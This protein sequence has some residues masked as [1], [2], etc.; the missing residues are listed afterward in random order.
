MP[1]VSSIYKDSISR[2]H[3]RFRVSQL[4]WL[5]LALEQ[6]PIHAHRT[7]SGAMY[8]GLPEIVVVVSAGPFNLR[9]H[10]KSATCQRQSEVK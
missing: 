9:A 10:P 7:C 4:P 2:Q 6:I 5:T 8:A 1:R 3:E